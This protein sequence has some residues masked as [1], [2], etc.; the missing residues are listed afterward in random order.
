MKKAKILSVKIEHCFDECPD[1]SYLGKFSDIPQDDAIIRY[2]DHCGK[3]V[4][5]LGE[6]DEMPS[7]SRKHRFFVP[8]MTGEETG[9]PESPRQD[10]Q[11]MESF[12][13]G[14]WHFIGIIAKARVQMPTGAIQTI[15]SGGLWGVESDSGKDYIAS[16]EHEELEGLRAELIAIGIS[17]RAVHYAFR[18]VEKNN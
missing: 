8:S 12:N 15:L 13:R 7:R 17:A 5:E 6:D 10:W 16:L 14:Q 3:M 2:G 4:S 11:R 1:T 18:N 9:N